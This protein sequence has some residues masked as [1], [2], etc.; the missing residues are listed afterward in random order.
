M[1]EKLQNALGV[2]GIAIYFII[3][4]IIGALPFVMINASFGVTILLIT[5][6]QFLPL[7]SLLFWIWGLICAINGKQ[8]LWSIAYYILFAALYIPFILD[9]FRTLF[10]ISSV[11]DFL[12]K[13]KKGVMGYILGIPLVVLQCMGIIGGIHNGSFPLPF[14]MAS[15]SLFIADLI[16]WISYLHL[17]ILGVF[18]IWIGWRAGFKKSKVAIQ[19]KDE[20]PEPKKHFDS[21]KQFFQR[22]KPKGA[23]RHLLILTLLGALSFSVFQNF[24]YQKMINQLNTEIDSLELS[25]DSLEVQAA[26]DKLLIEKYRKSN[27]E[28]SG[29]VYTLS[30]ELEKIK[31]VYE[32]CNKHIVV[33][34]DDGTRNYHKIGCWYFDDSYFWAYNK[35]LAEQKGYNPCSFCFGSF[36][37]S[38][39]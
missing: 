6:E 15:T 35:E 20:E 12:Q 13:V 11:N 23:F 31:P 4:F 14:S 30:Q 3:R 21:D 37:R 36:F 38:I 2:L 29:K 17:G 10:E 8:D 25:I 5:I 7:T 22:N 24:R 34:S 16:M 9:V 18:F 26:S 33:V 19:S 27:A 32:F 39:S 28:N 1:K